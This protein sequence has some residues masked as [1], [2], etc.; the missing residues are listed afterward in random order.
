MV[1]SS[2]CAIVVV[3]DVVEVSSL[4]LGAE[5]ENGLLELLGRGRLDRLDVLQR[6][7][8]DR[9]LWSLLLLL[10]LL[11][12][13]AA[14]RHCRRCRCCCCCC[15]CCCGGRRRYKWCWFFRC[16]RRRRRSENQWLMRDQRDRFDQVEAV[17]P[18]DCCDGCCCLIVS[19]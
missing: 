7:E 4:H 5:G 2:C 16:L 1:V 15:C 19:A 13:S 18:L 11:M 6:V 14:G 3:V 8:A 9:R 12:F 17:R 10:L